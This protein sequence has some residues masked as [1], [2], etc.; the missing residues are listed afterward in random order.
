VTTPPNVS[1]KCIN[2]FTAFDKRRSLGRGLRA[3]QE[4]PGHADVSTTTIY[5]HVLKGGRGVVSPLDGG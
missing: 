5:T 2:A 1:E 3:V 4:L